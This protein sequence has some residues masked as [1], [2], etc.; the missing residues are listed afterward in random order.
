MAPGWRL[1]T[2][3]G[4]RPW[5]DGLGAKNRYPWRFAGFQMKLGASPAGRPGL[6]SPPPRIPHAVTTTLTPK[7]SMNRN[8]VLLA[9]LPALCLIALQAASA[10]PPGMGNRFDRPQGGPRGFGGPMGGRGQ[11]ELLEE[12]DDNGD[13]WLNAEERKAARASIQAS[14]GNRGPRRGRSPRFGRSGDQPA[15]Q[16]GRKLDPSKVEH[17]SDADLYDPNVLRTLFL[18]FDS[19]DWEKELEAFKGSDVDVP[20]TLT[21]DGETYPGVGVHF[22]GMSSYMMV[23]TGMKRSLNVSLDLADSDQRIHGYKTLNL[24]NGAGDSSFMSTVLYSELAR[25]HIAA[26]KANMVEVVI[27]GESWGVYTNV[28]QC[29]KIF[30]QENYG[31]SKGTR[32]KAPGS[33]GGDAGLRYLGEELDDYQSRFKMK[34]SDGDKAWRALVELCR[35]LNET[36]TDQLVEE[37]SPQL[38]IDGTLWFLA[39]DAALVNSDGYWTRASDYYLFRQ[40]DGLFHVIPHD[41]NEALR[42]GPGGGGPPG[43][44]PPGA[45]GP[46]GGGPPGNFGPSG[47]FG[48]PG[49]GVPG[50]FGP[51]GDFRPPGNFRPVGNA[52]PRDAN[53]QAAQRDRRPRDTDAQERQRG[54][55]TRRDTAQAEQ[56]ERRQRGGRE[57]RN[58][59]RGGR[60]GPGHGSP[61]LDPLVG[62]DNERMPLRSRLLQVPELRERYLEYIRQ[63][64]DEQLDWRHLGPRVEHYR[65]QIGE[66]VTE[67]TRKLASNEAFNS[68]TASGDGDQQSSLQRFA[69]E[70][71][72]FLRSYQAPSP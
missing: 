15:P 32:W 57:G 14:G 59:R 7:L 10:Q 34:S 49:G 48:P 68:A 35:T 61:T 3:F 18:E 50:D 8:H 52:A 19:D 46:P 72:E 67:D 1:P 65:Q 30:T 69:E 5:Q 26:P 28:Q 17:F 9:L 56:R 31:S 37:L 58:G 20:A 47:D 54:R 63:I 33:P 60:G 41:M 42:G 6:T 66:A 21:V 13:G 53:T 39:Y 38:D 27:N 25:E 71:S 64:A 22:R 51:G 29:D 11:R 70:R 36:P 40:A 44:G 16:P 43:G 45:F 23:P 55:Q 12:F 4:S 62:I 2:N 24:L